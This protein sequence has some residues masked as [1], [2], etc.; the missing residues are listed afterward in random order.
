MDAVGLGVKQQAANTFLEKKLKKKTDSKKIDINLNYFETVEVSFISDSK[1]Y[2]I[3]VSIGMSSVGIG[4]RF[5]V[6]RS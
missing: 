2:L 1:Q 6:G 4:C 5:E 3:V